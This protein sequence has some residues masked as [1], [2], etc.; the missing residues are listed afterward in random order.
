M[1][2]GDI[3]SRTRHPGLYYSANTDALQELLGFLY[4]ECCT[5][6]KA[7]EPQPFSSSADESTTL[8]PVSAASSVDVDVIAPVVADQFMSAFSH[9]MKAAGCCEP[10]C[11]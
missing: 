6:T 4:A 8:K 9:A 3:G 2:A 7:I 11:R 1:I 10:G 5:R